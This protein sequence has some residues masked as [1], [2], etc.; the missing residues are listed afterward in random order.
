[1]IRSAGGDA[2]AAAAASG[3]G[4]AERI[5][6]LRFRFDVGSSIPGEKCFSGLD[7]HRLA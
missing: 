7:R 5:A 4:G 6:V 3:G 1:M 2:V